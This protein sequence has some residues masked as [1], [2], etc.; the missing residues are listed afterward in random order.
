MKKVYFGAL[1]FSLL[2]A[3]VG[4][5]S[6]VAAADSNI[7]LS[8]PYS[9]IKAGESLDV[10]VVVDGA[11]V[12]FN[13]AKSKI[14][15]S[16]N[17][18]VESITFG[19]CNF[20]FI[21]TPTLSNPSFVGV[22][23]GGESKFCKAYTMKVKGSSLG[24][25]TITLSD[26]TIRARSDARELGGYLQGAIISVVNDISLPI[27]ATAVGSVNVDLGVPKSLIT[28]S[29]DSSSASSSAKPAEF[30]WYTVNVKVTDTNNAPIEGAKV[31]LYTEPKVSATSS[32]GT[33]SYDMVPPGSHLVTVELNDQKVGEQILNVSGPDHVLTLGIKVQRPTVAQVPVGKVPSKVAQIVI[34][35]LLAIIVAAG[36][37]FFVAKRRKQT[38][39]PS[40]PPQ[41]PTDETP[42][43]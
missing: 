18:S 34:T 29:S 33:V 37:A 36:V 16:S 24:K 38:L 31:T 40:V 43:V 6:L 22:I 5:L 20:S 41:L 14:A 1:I 23:L 25:G 21:S 2:F 42:I 26:G 39:P 27:A 7:S 35:A 13:V 10:D 4:S 3:F 32:A 8:P 30:A 9:T 28:T 12:P 17:L 15:L 19:D 11:G